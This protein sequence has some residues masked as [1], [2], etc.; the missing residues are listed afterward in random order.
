MHNHLKFSLPDEYNPQQL[1]GALAD[2]YAIKK[3]RPVLKRMAIYDTFDWRLFNKSFILYTSEDKLFLRKLFQNAVIQSVAI[4]S[5]PVFIWDFPD[6]ELKERLAPVLR[7]RALFKLIELHSRLMGHRILNSDEKTVARL[8]YEEVKSARE[9]NAPVLATYLWLQPVKGYTKDCQNLT[10]HLEKAGFATHKKED[11]YFKAIEAAGK[12][13]GSYS[14]KL[15]IQLDPA[16][17]SD[18]AAKIILRYLLQIMKINE[19]YLEKDLDTEFLHDFR[20]AIRRTRSAL[21]QIKSV[22]PQNTTGRFKK[23]FAY[24]GKLS[25]Q[26]RDLDVY[27]LKE[28]AFKAMLPPVLRDDIAPLFDYLRKNRS[29]AL[30]QVI[31]GLKSKK[32]AQ[33]MQDWE[34]FLDEP[35]QDPPKA[36]SADVPIIA[37]ARKRIYRQY[38]RIVEDGSRILDNTE[39]AKLH[40]LRIECKKLRYLMEFFS[41]LFPHK[42]IN[43]LIVQLKTLQDNLGDFNDLCVQEEYLLNIAGELPST[44]RKAKKSLV[45]IGSLIAALD[46]EKQIIKDAFAK[47]FT[48]YASP[49]NKKAFG[50][51]FASKQKETTP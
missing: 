14:S 30:Q 20:V 9:K 43:I 23:E 10:K 21:G 37:L 7:M 1:T 3:E 47:T 39:D 48:D 2:H 12:N 25:N 33:I 4:T 15:K 24:V 50:E 51:L 27:L 31:R 38:R 13:P 45:A 6:G 18:E 32:Y 40:A 26:L 19:A 42:K 46:R 28:D 44:H 5:P 16:M 11:I 34:T 8:I 17:R 22:F 49:P 41:S 36:S 29:K 35:V